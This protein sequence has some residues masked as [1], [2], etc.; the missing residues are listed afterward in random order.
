MTDE[1]TGNKPSGQHRGRKF[2]GKRLK[3]SLPRPEPAAALP[4]P[5]SAERIAKVMARAGLCSRREA[6]AWIA[7]GRVAVN[8]AVISSPALDVTP[9]DRIAVDGKPLPARERT[10]LFL[11]HKRRGLMTTHAD[12]QGR[13]TIFGALPK[14]LPRLV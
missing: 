6:E 14:D 7:A 8:G 5:K 10:R 3:T 13:P 9:A 12:P 4:P 1:K 11:Y 2:R